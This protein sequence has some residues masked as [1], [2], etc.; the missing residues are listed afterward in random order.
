MSDTGSGYSTPTSGFMKL[1]PIV[2]SESDR[3]FLR[4]LNDYIEIELRKV[5]PEDDEQR[6]IVYK[7]AFNKV[8]LIFHTFLSFVLLFTLIHKLLS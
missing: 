2:T 7:T 5:N 1:P 8:T 4:I 6:Y 3:Q